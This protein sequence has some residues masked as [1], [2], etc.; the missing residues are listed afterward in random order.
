[1]I[2]SK[3]ANQLFSSLVFK[4]VKTMNHVGG[5]I[6]LSGSG[7][8]GRIAYLVARSFNLVLKSLGK[9]QVFKYLISGKTFF[10]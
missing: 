6:V 4:F 5:V 8:S 3:C 10:H 1:M 7:T 9:P 2:A